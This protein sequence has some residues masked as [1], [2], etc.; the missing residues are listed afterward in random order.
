MIIH[1]E[2]NELYRELSI[3]IPEQ[4]NQSP[5]FMIVVM[6]PTRS[7]HIHLPWKNFSESCRDGLMLVLK[8]MG[9]SEW[10]AWSKILDYYNENI[11]E[12]YS[13][14]VCGRQFK[15]LQD[16]KIPYHAYPVIRSNGYDQLCA[17]SMYDPD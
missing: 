11:V 13:C 5:E 1:K 10:K 8:G 15:K 17:G 7:T 14:K 9:F 6:T 3:V 12:K 4:F 16:G 2:T